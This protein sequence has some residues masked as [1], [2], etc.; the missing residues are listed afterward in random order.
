M[1]SEKVENSSIV[2]FVT[3]PTTMQFVFHWDEKYLRISKWLELRSHIRTWRTRLF[4]RRTAVGEHCLMFRATFAEV[5]L[6]RVKWWLKM[7]SVISR[8]LQQHYFSGRSSCPDDLTSCFIWKLF[9]IKVKVQFSFKSQVTR[10]Y[11]CKRPIS[12]NWSR[13]R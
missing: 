13:H 2:C 7:T 3:W 11:N 12:P 8:C 4:Q 6:F 5:I 9:R 10:S 1:G